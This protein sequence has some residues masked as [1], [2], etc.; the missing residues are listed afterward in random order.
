MWEMIYPYLFSIG[1]E[2]LWE[3]SGLA[4]AL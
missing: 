2:D 1:I 4:N 3:L